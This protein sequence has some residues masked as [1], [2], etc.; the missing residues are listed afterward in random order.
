MKRSS[1]A[2]ASAPPR[3]RWRWR[4]TIGRRLLAGFAVA[5]VLLTAVGGISYYNT[6][7]LRSNESAVT[8]ARSVMD[9]LQALGVTLSRAENGERGYL[10]TNDQDSL[11]PFD[12]ARRSVDDLIARVAAST[13]SD[14]VQRNL[15]RELRPL[16]DARFALMSR[17]IEARRGQGL[18]AASALEATD[19][20][21]QLMSGVETVVGKMLAAQRAVVAKRQDASAAAAT[22]TASVVLGGTALALVSLVLLALWLTRGITTPINELSRRIDDIANGDGDLTRRVDETRRDEVGDLARRFNRFV[23]GIANLVRDIA[24]SATSAAA[25]AQELSTVSNEMSQS[26]RQ[27]HQ[28]AESAASAAEEVSRS[29]HTVA[30]GTEEMT[31][32]VGDIARSAANASAAGRTAVSRSEDATGTVTKLGESSAAITDV[33]AIINGIAEQTNLLALNATIEAARAGEAGRGFGIVA[34]EVK[35]LAQETA[36]ATEDITRR[37]TAIQ[38]EVHRAV[39]AISVT[40][41]VIGEVNKHQGTIADAVQAQSSTTEGM[42]RHIAE[43]AAGTGRIADNVRLIAHTTQAT[44]EGIGQVRTS[45]DELA[46]VSERLQTM[47]GRFRVDAG[48]PGSR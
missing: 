2:P 29:V 4:W 27:A 21:Q 3:G 12:A 31:A 23:D 20:G 39:S 34:G 8:H 5:L 40:G 44:A 25:A 11:A 6:T 45:A 22:S 36:K 30:E 14:L 47:V 33:V 37:I 24:E 7:R 9:D 28:E 32:S 43:A 10:I 16:V 41:E 19:L 35:D 26:A 42:G 1:G 48:L 38:T 15:I 13:H 17:I 18:A 46:M